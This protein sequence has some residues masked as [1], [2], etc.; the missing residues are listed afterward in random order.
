MI[1]VPLWLVIGTAIAPVVLIS[2]VVVALFA[3][4]GAVTELEQLRARTKLMQIDVF[5]ARETFAGRD[6]RKVLS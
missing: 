6:D 4:F 5:A 1:A 3:W 2:G